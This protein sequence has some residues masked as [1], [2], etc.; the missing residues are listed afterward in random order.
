[1]QQ[2]EASITKRQT[3]SHQL[4]H[5]AYILSQHIT[6]EHKKYKIHATVKPASWYGRLH[7]V[8]SG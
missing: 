6:T 4:L 5:T 7:V 1:M 3:G 2:I 8:T